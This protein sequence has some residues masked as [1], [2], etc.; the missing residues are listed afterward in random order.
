MIVR[1]DHVK[2]RAEATKEAATAEVE[3]APAVKKPEENQA[4]APAQK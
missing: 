2:M 3:E 1:L 4:D